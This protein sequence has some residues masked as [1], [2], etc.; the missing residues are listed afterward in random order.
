M[1]KKKPS[2][3]NKKAGIFDMFDNLW[4]EKPKMAKKK[5]SVETEAPGIFDHLWGGIKVLSLGLKNIYIFF[6]FSFSVY[7]FRLNI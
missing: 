1:A 3:E 4:S 6:F 7:P 5:E 2:G